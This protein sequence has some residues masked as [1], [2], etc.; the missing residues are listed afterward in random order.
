[1]TT[2]LV[3]A[4]AGC[5]VVLI[6]R[7][8][9]ETPVRSTASTADRPTAVASDPDDLRAEI[10]RLQRVVGGLAAQQARLEKGQT[11]RP[12]KADDGAEAATE[13]TAAALAARV[14]KDM[15]VKQYT[16]AAADPRGSQQLET[17]LRKQFAQPSFAET[18]VAVDEADCRGDVCK[19]K[20]SHVQGAETTFLISEL[21][22]VLPD[23]QGF[24]AFDRSGDKAIIE[25]Y[26]LR[27]VAS[28]RP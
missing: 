2:W 11:S 13:E 16:G 15:V 20:L 26:L 8:L 17:D 21:A 12:H 27:G 9:Q 24:F 6:H 3:T 28:A 4:V 7:L 25:T 19:V 1:M 5:A 23:S 22:A 10:A 14:S 18:G